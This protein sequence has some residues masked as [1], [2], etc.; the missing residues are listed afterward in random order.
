MTVITVG[1]HFGMIVIV[2]QY[3]EAESTQKGGSFVVAPP[4]IIYV[5][6]QAFLSRTTWKVSYLSDRFQETKWRTYEKG[7]CAERGSC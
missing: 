1:I 7:K 5:S 2:G 4:K 6:V 3:M